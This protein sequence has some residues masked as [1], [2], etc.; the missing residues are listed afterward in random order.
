MFKIP[1]YSPYISCSKNF[2][3]L[4]NIHS[5]LDRSSALPT[6]FCGGVL[7][8]GESGD[9]GV[10][11]AVPDAFFH[12]WSFA[13]CRGCGGHLWD[14]FKVEGSVRAL[15]SGAYPIGG[16]R[17]R[18]ACG[19][20]FGH[21]LW[22]PF[23]AAFPALGVLLAVS[24]VESLAQAPALPSGVYPAGKLQ[25]HFTCGFDFRHSLWVPFVVAFAVPGG[26]LMVPL[27]GMGPFGPGNRFFGAVEEGGDFWAV[28]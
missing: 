24:K 26:L 22:L 6:K 17:W 14:V 21:S 23:V 10:L 5:F 13:G 11:S 18:F 8:S 3:H 7:Y 20:N 27:G 1:K 12:I 16:L 15:P 9:N 28:S 2:H 19:F 25:W 4:P